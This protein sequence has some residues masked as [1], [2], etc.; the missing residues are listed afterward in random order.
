MKLK[1][2][3]FIVVICLLAFFV[4]FASAAENVAGRT[5][6]LSGPR[7]PKPKSPKSDPILDSGILFSATLDSVTAGP[8]AQSYPPIYTHTLKLTVRKVFRG[9]LKPGQTIT[10]NHQTRQHKMPTFP[11][12]KLCLVTVSDVRGSLNVDFIKEATGDLLSKAK[13]AKS[14]PVGWTLKGKERMMVSPW[15]SM[16]KGFWPKDSKFTKD[17]AVCSVTGRPALFVGNEI[18]FKVAPVPPVKKIKWTNSDGDGLYKVTVTNPTK[19]PLIVH[20]LLKD[21][22][23]ILWNESIAMICNKAKPGVQP[24]PGCK[25]VP[26]TVDRVILQPGQSVSGQI[27]VFGLKGVEWPRGGYRIE[28]MF[29][30]GE[31]S[32]KHS[33]YY[34][35]RHHDKVRDK[36]QAEFK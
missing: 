14:M 11:K 27:N 4:N 7:A 10:A 2:F 36:V 8:V 17:M 13:L 3:K 9:N 1:S 24:A 32:A 31:K 33:F 22:D 28:F 35:S 25:K 5:A 16:G 23:R 21:G 30:L 29:A 26:K 34:L 15:A 19:R 12:N 18:Q 20:A 6:G